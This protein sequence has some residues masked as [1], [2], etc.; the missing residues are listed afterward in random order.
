VLN[1]MTA[2]EYA[3][4]GEFLKLRPKLNPYS[5]RNRFFIVA[6]THEANKGEHYHDFAAH[7]NFG[8][9]RVLRTNNRIDQE[10]A[11]IANQLVANAVI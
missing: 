5:R 10:K 1:C 7:L 9:H 3:S 6:V 8:S 11:V 4:S 2:S